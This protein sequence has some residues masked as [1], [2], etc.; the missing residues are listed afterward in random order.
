MSQSRI[1]NHALL[2]SALALLAL[3]SCD[4]P[5]T[6]RSNLDAPVSTRSAETPTAWTDLADDPAS[7]LDFSRGPSPSSAIFDAQKA[8]SIADPPTPYTLGDVVA[9]PEKSNG[10]PGVLLLDYDRD[11]DLDI[12]A[13]NGPGR[14]NSLFSNQRMETGA[15]TFI[16]V[17][18]AAGVGSLAQ[19]S[20]GACFG[21]IDNDGDED[22]Y[23][24][25]RSEPNVL[26]E[27]Q[28]DGTFVDITAAAGVGGGSLG[29]TSCSMGDVDG[30]GLLDIAVANSFDWT[31]RAAIFVDDF[32][33]SDP[34]QLFVSAG[35]NTFSDESDAS[36]IRAL[37]GFSDGSSGHPTITWAIAMVD[38]DLDGDTDILHA[39][40]QAAKPTSTFGGLDRGLVHALINDGTGHF[41]DI[42]P[43][44]GLDQPGQWMGLTFGDF[45]RDGNLDFFGTNMGGY[46]FSVLPLPYDIEETNA[47]WF[48]GNGD[49]T[50]DDP[51]VGGV[52]STPFGWGP[53]ALDYDND[54]DTDIVYF[55]SLDGTGPVGTADNP[56]VLLNNEGLTGED[57]SFT[58]DLV[59]LSGTDHRRRNVNGSAVGDLDGDGSVDVVSVSASDYFAS[60]LVPYPAAFGGA[61]D[62][63]ATFF[64]TFSET[65]PGEFTWNGIPQTEGTISVQRNAANHGHNSV[66]IR[67]LG[68]VGLTTGGVANRDGFGAVLS[69]TPKN[70]DTV[71]KP[72]V[73]GSGYSSQDG[74]DAVFGLAHEHRGQLD[75]L[76]P[77]G[78]RNR[79]PAV[80]DEETL[81][82]PEIPCDYR[83]DHWAKFKDYKT[84][85]QGALSELRNQGVLTHHE[86]KRLRKSAFDAW[87]QSKHES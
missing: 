44:A 54:G 79:I 70:G 25:G 78:V 86:A 28:G 62:A 59:S 82:V 71:M 76:W 35:G 30:D 50:W 1:S 60:P 45:N 81:L 19:D 27:N 80:Y 29:H 57:A 16:D 73:G 48:L 21:D 61:Y 56:G 15:T 7:G 69:F 24:L 46:A 51:G 40:D 41:T 58:A 84:C 31:T 33:S 43:E 12:Y 6:S 63:T 18:A 68:T 11:G 9:T 74:T 23:V 75:V 65:G 66:T 85:V 47:R 72:V 3:P 49:N 39:D 52:V 32:A 13:T 4:A 34:N 67:T 10:A 5:I 83:H 20:T 42:T 55:G 64:P 17:A 8:A 36:G 87:R 14:S 26:F 77:G 38:I 37:R 22:L 53:S 2:L